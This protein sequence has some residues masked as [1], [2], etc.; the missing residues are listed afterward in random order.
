MKVPFMGPS[1]EES[2]INYDKIYLHIVL[3]RAIEKLICGNRSLNSS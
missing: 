3:T 2:I 1:K